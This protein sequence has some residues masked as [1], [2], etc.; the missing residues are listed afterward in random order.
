[1]ENIINSIRESLQIP[2]Y[3]NI[4]PFGSRALGLEYPESDFD[5]CILYSNLNNS[6][7]H[8]QKLLDICNC[9]LKCNQSDLVVVS[10]DDANIDISFTTIDKYNLNI[11]HIQNQMKILFPTYESK[12]QYINSVREAYI[13]DN[14]ELQQQLK[15]WMIP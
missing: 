2:N 4:V 8:I 1:M 14:K 6:T 12:L 10:V 15:S 13:S 5:I 7:K 9:T 3:I 11:I